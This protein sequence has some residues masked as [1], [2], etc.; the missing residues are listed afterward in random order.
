MTQT[1]EVVEPL[2]GYTVGITA[3]R[4]REEFGAALERRGAR[5]V[6]AP[7]IR[8][9]PLADDTELRAA[10]NGCLSGP[11]D[12]VVATTGIGYRGWIEAADSWGMLEK[13]TEQLSGA[14]IIARGP[15][16]K[17]AIRAS[18]LREAWSPESESSSDVLEHLVENY[19]LQG[20]RIADQLHGE[21]LP[22]VVET[23]RAAGADVIEVPVYRWVPP[24]DPSPLNRLIEATAAGAVDCVAFTSAPA[25]VSYL[26]AAE[27]LGLGHVVREALR[28]PVVAACVGPVTASPLLRERIP[29]IQPVRSRLG[30]L[31]REIVD[32][33]PRRVGRVLPVAGHLMDVRGQAAVVD[34]QLIPLSTSS[35][36]L[37]RALIATPGH[38]V[39]RRDLLNVT[40]GEGG[41]EHAVEVAIGRLRTALGDPRIILTV[42]KRGYR[43]AYEPERMLEGDQQWRY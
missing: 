23:L 29:V 38:I 41:D 16:A 39:S 42:V 13:L 33:V 27:H 18:G 15:K 20:R 21:P 19:H 6:Y 25:V 26:Q 5:I 34:G 3:A 28:G 1:T 40:P 4:R 30:A 32:E 11:L 17:G 36:A 43:L 22:D 35:M 8:I 7:A 37:L 24:E 2:A 14:T 12:F 31:V 9:V 10:T